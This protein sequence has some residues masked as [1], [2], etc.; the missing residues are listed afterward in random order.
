HARRPMRRASK[1]ETPSGRQMIASPSIIRLRPEPLGGLHNRGK[2]IGPVVTAPSEA[3]HPR[4]FPPHHEAEPVVLYFVHPF[5]PR[6]RLRGLGRSAGLNKTGWA[7]GR[8]ITHQ[9]HNRPEIG[10]GR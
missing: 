3:S 1:S 4:A 7:P 8:T 10:A 5:W 6:G 9:N 2:P